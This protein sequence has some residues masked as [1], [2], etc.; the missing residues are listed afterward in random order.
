MR[1][2]SI[3]HIIGNSLVFY[4]LIATI[5][6]SSSCKTSEK[7][8]D[9]DK[10]KKEL[11]TKTKITLNKLLSK[12]C[13]KTLEEKEK[14][15]KDIKTK[16]IEDAEVKVLIKKLET[17]ISSEKETIKKKKEEDE[18]IRREK[19]KADAERRAREAQ[20]RYKLNKFFKEIINATDNKTAGIKINEALDLFVSESS[21]VLIIVGEDGDEIDYDKPTNIRKYLNYLKDQKKNLN[22]IE[23]IVFDKNKKI[24]TL[25]LRKK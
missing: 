6:F 12:E 7:V 13:T 1:N 8:V 14:I 21:N 15:L 23:K 25:V 20:P 3:K 24:K 10:E 18:R 16:N 22:K 11:I 4:L 17:K 9:K 19:E 2:F 5:T